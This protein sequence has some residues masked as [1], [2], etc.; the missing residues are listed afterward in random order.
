MVR[1]SPVRDYDDDKLVDFAF[2]VNQP[3]GVTTEM[4]M[5]LKRAIE[6]ADATATKLQQTA[7][8][9]AIVMA[10]CTLWLTGIAF[11]KL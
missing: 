7:I 5:R 4:Q 8:A 10:V 2:E 9:L 11:A 6:K 3:T 1:R